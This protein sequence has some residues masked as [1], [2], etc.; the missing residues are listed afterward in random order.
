[1]KSS[2]LTIALHLVVSEGVVLLTSTAVCPRQVGTRVSAPAVV[3]IITLID[4]LHSNIS[5][6]KYYRYYRYFVIGAE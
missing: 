1:M 4:V 3:P 5:I 2:V 6:M